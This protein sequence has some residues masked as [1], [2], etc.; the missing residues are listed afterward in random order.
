MSQPISTHLLEEA[1][2]LFGRKG[3]ALAWFYARNPN[4]SGPRPIDEIEMG[5]E[6]FVAATLDA[7]DTPQDDLLT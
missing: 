7:M 5:G 1:E 4:L 6:V 3:A 2:R